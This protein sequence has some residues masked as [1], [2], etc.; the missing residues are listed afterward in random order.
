MGL[1][2]MEVEALGVR[3]LAVGIAM[4]GMVAAIG[5]ERWEE[6][7]GGVTEGKRGERRKE[8]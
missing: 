6:E 3:H 5:E 4:V 1:G 8:I 2:G 7:G